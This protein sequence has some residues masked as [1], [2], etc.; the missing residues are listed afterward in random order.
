MNNDSLL[1][2]VQNA[3]LLLALVLV[4]DLISKNWKI[5]QSN[6]QKIFT[7]FIVG[8]IGI[9]IMF[10]PWV[11]IPG[12]IF[13]TRSILLGI[14]GLFFG[15]IP[16]IIAMLMTAAMRIYQG[17]SGAIMG[18]SVIFA[19]G[20]I[21]ILWGYLR[22]RS[23]QNISWLELYIFGIVIHIVMLGLAF[24][25]P[26]ETALRVFSSIAIPVMLIYPVG[27]AV[28]GAILSSHLQRDVIFEKIQENETRYKIVADNTYDWEYWFG[29]DGKFVYCSP[30]C[31]E[32][33]GYSPEELIENPDITWK[34]VHPDDIEIYKNHRETPAIEKA[35]KPIQ[36][37]II[38]KDGSIRWIGHICRPVFGKNGELLGT[39]GSNRD[40]TIQTLAECKLRESEEKYRELTESLA[41]VIWI[42]DVE[43]LYFR[44]VSQSVEKLR[45]Y[46]VEEV[47]K[48]PIDAALPPETKEGFKVLIRSRADDFLNGTEP[49]DRVYIDEVE[50]PCKDGSMVWTEV[51]TS[52]Y[53]NDETGRV[54]IRG[55]SRDISERKRM[56]TALNKE[57]NLIDGIMN[58]VPGL[59]YLYDDQGNL[60]RWNK[61]HEEITG[62]SAQ[63]LHNFKLLDWYKDS[64]EDIEKVTAGVK[65]ALEEGFASTEAYLQTKSGEK[66]LYDLTASRLVFGNKTYFTG[67]GIDISVRRQNE[68]KIAAAQQEIQNTLEKLQHELDENEKSRWA[69]LS[70]IEDQKI[71]QEA[72]QQEQSLVTSLM[73]TIPDTIYFKDVQGRFIRTNKAQAKKL[74][75]ADPKDLLG[76]TDFDFFSK[77]HAQRAFENEHSIIQNGHP[78]INREELLTYENKNAEWVLTTKM[79]LY[80]LNHEIIGTYGV[81]RDISEIKLAEEQLQT[82]YDATLEGWAAALELR[83]KGT[84]KHSRNVVNLTLNLA[85]ELGVSQVDLAHIYRGSLLHDIGKLGIPDEILLSEGE[86]KP[87]EWIEMKKHPEYAYRMLYPIEYLRPALEIPYSHHEKWDGSGYP[88]GL[89][90]EEIPLSARIFSVID[91][92]DALLEDRTYRR[93]W[94]RKKVIA[95]LKDQSGK[96][97][98]P[99]VVETFLRMITQ[100]NHIVDGGEIE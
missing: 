38:C 84:A 14:C 33:S 61:K 95:Y 57:L 15:V 100:Q 85:T 11:L 30:S 88:R 58:S 25:M 80:N 98:D 51:S 53:T 24:T 67:I 65:K 99:R 77:E 19:T 50:Q 1:G 42:L 31:K 70:M 23:M 36:F 13:D 10:T 55:V 41:D 73:D 89:K 4:F 64:P 20:T 83:E 44:Y 81:T 27:T 37:R 28:L 74:G 66:L 48:D 6:F 96:Q 18:V 12:L 59:L 16:T 90:G 93:A 26:L 29:M 47:M 8:G 49:F 34:M 9:A 68:L 69:M 21:G 40:I 62:Y 91:V 5:N 92:W 45:G 79:P 87:H 56:E 75:V 43:T 35:G 17:G 63:E 71:A 82:A 94:D 97:F 7:G 54:E 32:V 52:F 3:S 72:L 2:L 39:R 86:L 22:K 76:K 46:S 78:I 60:I